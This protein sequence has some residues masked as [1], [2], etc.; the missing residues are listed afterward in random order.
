M[1]TAFCIYGMIFILNGNAS[2]TLREKIEEN[3]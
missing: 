3:S 2:I 1:A